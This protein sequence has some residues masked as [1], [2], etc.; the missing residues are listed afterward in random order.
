MSATPQVPARAARRASNARTRCS[1]CCPDLSAST[2]RRPPPT[3]FSTAAPFPRVATP[4]QRRA[5]SSGRLV[6]ALRSEGVSVCVVEDSRRPREARCGVPQQL[7][8]LSRRRHAG[9]LSAAERRPPRRATA[10][11]DRFRGTRARL[12][13]LAPA[14]S[15]P[16][17][18]RRDSISKA[19][20]AS[21]WITRSA[22][23]MPASRRAPTRRCSAM[24]V[25]ARLRGGELQRR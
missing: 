25:G 22:L 7:G 21:C 5:R 11:R 24:G 16:L 8:E 1:W 17:R 4:R 15:H 19:P 23:P 18:E 6:Q 12:Q 20:A 3:P 9:A 2:R 13:G 14:R 10:G